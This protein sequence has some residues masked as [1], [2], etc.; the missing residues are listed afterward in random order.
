MTTPTVQ[1]ADPPTFRLLVELP[2]RWQAYIAYD[3]PTIFED[4]ED[5]DPWGRAAA[6]DEI[7]R[8]QD[9]GYHLV[10]P[11][12]DPNDR[13]F[14]RFR[15]VDGH[16][17][18]YVALRHD[19][20]DVDKRAGVWRF[21]APSGEEYLFRLGRDGIVWLPAHWADRVRDP[22]YDL[23]ENDI[24]P[25][26]NRGDPQH[27]PA[28]DISQTPPGWEPGYPADPPPEDLE[29][30]DETACTAAVEALR[31]AG[32]AIEQPLDHIDRMGW[33]LQA[34][35]PSA[36]TSSPVPRRRPP[37]PAN[38]TPTFLA[39]TW[40]VDDY[41]QWNAIPFH[42]GRPAARPPRRRRAG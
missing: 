16:L 32:W 41:T 21:L 12:D 35:G 13:D 33:F 5:D 8:I 22:D 18:T 42:L 37:D 26:D 34:W 29:H 38:S 28:A 7:A 10:G 2:E 36:R 1:P 20:L 31:R 30:W 15:G 40:N 6:D 24:R 39:P 11:A 9:Q 25:S 4:D 17:I 27:P 19:I 23:D 14:G 3:D